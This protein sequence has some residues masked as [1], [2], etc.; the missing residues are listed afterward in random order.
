MSDLKSETRASRSF[1]V[2][3]SQKLVLDMSETQGRLYSTASPPPEGAPVHP[4]L[5]ARAYDP[6]TEGTLGEMVRSAPNFDVY[7]KQLI[8][9]DFDIASSTQGM[10]LALTEPHRLKNGDTVIGAMWS[11]GGQFTTLKHQPKP[12]SQMF[13]HATLTM[14]DEEIAKELLKTLQS[15]STFVELKDKI[16]EM[17]YTLHPMPLYHP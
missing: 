16:A 17:G 1:A 3:K 14:Y 4:F 15:T 6:F 2:Y 11:T 12:A 9:A 13:E 8:E 7:I 10:K 5:N